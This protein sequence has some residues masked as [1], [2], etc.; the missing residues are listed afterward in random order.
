VETVPRRGYR[1]LAEVHAVGPSPAGRRLELRAPSWTA[2][3]KR[4]VRLLATAAALL[5][6]IGLAWWWTAAS[7]R[8]PPTSVE[9]ITRLTWF[10][11]AS[12][13]DLD[14]AFSPDDGHSA[15]GPDRNP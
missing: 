14:L 10:A 5:A 13:L 9:P 2:R 7:Q 11:T 6:A 8:R 3:H 4:D 15:Y 12:P 1:F